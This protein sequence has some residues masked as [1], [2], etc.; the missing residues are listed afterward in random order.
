MKRLMC[1][2]CGGDPVR[3]SQLKFVNW[4]NRPQPVECPH[5][6]GGRHKRQLFLTNLA[7]EGKCVVQGHYE[8]GWH[9]TP[10]GVVFDCWRASEPKGAT[11]RWDLGHLSDSH[12]FLYCA[13]RQFAVESVEETV[14][15]LRTKP[16]GAYKSIEAQLDATAKAAR[17]V[18][19]HG[20]PWHVA[21]RQHGAGVALPRWLT[22]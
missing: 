11:F 8:S 1:Q 13:G 16:G 20:V 2:H 18:Q 6:E 5:E 4:T 7:R 10:F 21:I 19:A 9:V 17:M 12:G 22:G 14:Q 15:W 3:G